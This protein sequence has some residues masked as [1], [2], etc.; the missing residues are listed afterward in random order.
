MQSENQNNNSQQDIEEFLKSLNQTIAKIDNESHQIIMALLHTNW[1]RAIAILEQAKKTMAESE[2]DDQMSTED[3]SQYLEDRRTMVRSLA[4]MRDHAVILRDAKRRIAI[5][6][7]YTAHDPTGQ[8]LNTQACL[9]DESQSAA[10][11][12]SSDE[13]AS[14]Q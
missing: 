10:I 12:P 7:L 14:G 3:R 9:D 13:P 1:D 2:P 6:G 11:P 8:K 4:S 5:L